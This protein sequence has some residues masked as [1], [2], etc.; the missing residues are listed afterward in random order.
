MPW[1]IMLVPAL[2]VVQIR[3]VLDNTLVCSCSVGDQQPKL[4]DPSP[5]LQPMYRA[6]PNYSIYL[7]LL[8]ERASSQFSHLQELV[9][10]VRFAALLILTW[11]YTEPLVL[12]GRIEPCF[13]A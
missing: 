10:V 1:V 13:P 6:L 8:Y 4:F 12:M 7:N 5:V 2:T 11:F 3:K 9:N